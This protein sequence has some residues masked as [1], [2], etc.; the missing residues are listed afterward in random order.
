[1]ILKLLRQLA[2]TI[3]VMA[4]L[5]FLPAGRLDWPGAWLFLA[6]MGLVGLAMGIWLDRHDPELLAERMKPIFQRTQ[7]SWDRWL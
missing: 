1:M 7:P 5:L 3:A 4:I 2:L 6:E